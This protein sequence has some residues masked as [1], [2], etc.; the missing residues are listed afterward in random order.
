MK[1]SAKKLQVDGEVS[2]QRNNAAVTEGTAS[3]WNSAYGQAANAF[4]QIAGQAASAAGT[5]NAQIS[6]V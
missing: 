3:S 6:S 4:A 1:L 5:I 2:S